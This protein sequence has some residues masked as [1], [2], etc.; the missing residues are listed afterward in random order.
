MRTDMI[1]IFDTDAKRTTVNYDGLLVTIE[2]V[3]YLD[4]AYQ[5]VLED[6][7]LEAEYQHRLAQE[8]EKVVENIIT[9]G[10]K[11]IPINK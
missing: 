4:K 6:I 7:R 5:D 10:S 9:A 3:K 1:I 8:N 2:D 11:P